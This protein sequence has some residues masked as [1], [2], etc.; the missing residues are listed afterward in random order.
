[1][2]D[3]LIIDTRL[4]NV[5]RPFACSAP[6]AA[7]VGHCSNCM[8]VSSYSPHFCLQDAR[9]GWVSSWQEATSEVRRWPQPDCQQQRMHMSPSNLRLLKQAAHVCTLLK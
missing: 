4:P 7:L 5:P 8:T 6:I 9:N 1:M 3:V 2:L